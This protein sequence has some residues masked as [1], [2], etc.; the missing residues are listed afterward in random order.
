LLQACYLVKTLSGDERKIYDLIRRRLLSAW[1]EDHV[2]SV[3]TVITAI[4]NGDL[5]DR[6]HTSGSAVQQAG[7]KVLDVAAERR[8]KEGR[9]N[10]DQA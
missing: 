8:T 4:R 10:G 5:I 9:V 7:W 6:Y 2:W 1:Q 3:T